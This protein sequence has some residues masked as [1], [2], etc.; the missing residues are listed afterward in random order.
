MKKNAEAYKPFTMNAHVR[1]RLE[2]WE[3]CCNSNFEKIRKSI[4]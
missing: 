2:M 3:G 4:H 1:G